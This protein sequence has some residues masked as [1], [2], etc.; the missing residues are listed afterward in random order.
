MI[1]IK[2]LCTSLS[3]PPK[4]K[5]EKKTIKRGFL[6]YKTGRQDQDQFW[7]R[8]EKRR[9]SRN[10]NFEL[11]RTDFNFEGGTKGKSKKWYRRRALR[12]WR[13]VPKKGE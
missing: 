8:H 2:R 1:L 12:G 6:A 10:P 11:S 13:Y 9:Q 7:V 3:F 5:R 4:T